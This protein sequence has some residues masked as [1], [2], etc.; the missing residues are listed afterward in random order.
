MLVGSWGVLIFL[1]FSQCTHLELWA[2][3]FRAQLMGTVKAI[4][5]LS[6]SL[7]FSVIFPIS[8]LLFNS[9][10]NVTVVLVPYG[11]SSALLIWMFLLFLIQEFSVNIPFFQSMGCST[12][13]H[14]FWYIVVF[15][16]IQLRWLSVSSYFLNL[17][18]I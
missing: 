2:P 7:I 1:S 11:W 5:I 15:I 13:C 14:R 17:W 6:I 12:E 8:F 18:F 16:F 10:F 4:L 9:L 3:F